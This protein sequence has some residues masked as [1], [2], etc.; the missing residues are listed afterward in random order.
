VIGVD[1]AASTPTSRSRRALA[2]ASATLVALAVALPAALS[3]AAAGAAEQPQ[4]AVADGAAWLASRQQPTGAVPGFGGDWSMTAFAAAGIDAGS[5]RANGAAYSVRDF[6]HRRVWTGGPGSGSDWLTPS[7]TLAY[8]NLVRLATDYERAIIAAWAGGLDPARLSARQNLVAQLA[9]IYHPRPVT[10]DDPDVGPTEGSFGSPALFNG[11]VFGLLALERVADADRPRVPRA[12]LHRIVRTI[13]GN[14][15][16]D[17][18]W[19]FKRVTSQADRDERSDPEL[20]AATL[21]ALCRAG[22]AAD[23][24]LVADGFGF[25]RGRL[26]ADGAIAPDYSATSDTDVT[27]WVVQAA[28]ACGMGDTWPAGLPDG[29]PTPTAFLL[30]RQR[31][32]GSFRATADDDNPAD[33]V[34][35]T[36]AAVG[37]LAGGADD[38]AAGRAGFGADPPAGASWS[39]PRVARGTTVPLTLA[40]VAGDEDDDDP[41]VDVRLCRVDA[42]VGSTV[43]ELLQRAASQASPPGCVTDLALTPD[44]AAVASL[45]GESAPAGRQWSTRRDGGPV[46]VAGSDREVC[47]GDTVSVFLAP[48]AAAE[49]AGPSCPNVASD[50][51]PYVPDPPAPDPGPGTTPGPPGPQPAPGTTPT[52]AP[53][54]APTPEADLPRAPATA[55]LPRVSL[56]ISSARL[57]KSGRMTVRVGCPRKGAPREGCR[58][59]LTAS[60]RHRSWQDGALTRK[61]IGGRTTTVE[62]GRTRTIRF[63]VKAAFRR[64]LRR[65]GRRSVRVEARIRTRDGATGPTRTAQRRVRR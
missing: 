53:P 40:I 47:H 26:R 25:L 38:G 52:P 27:S 5:V 2:T 13:A 55:K 8:G 59:V 44:Q 29:H 48:V 32:D 20:T 51:D 36:Q 1:R 28:H 16:D 12:L 46:T 31:P 65:A 24:P 60:S 49:S 50:P 39:A 63:R 54:P 14:R 4:A 19:T 62:R 23:D 56:R 30:D 41:D 7:T 22:V 11:A 64:D 10:P 18:G 9:G 58:V 33:D 61:R 42:P 57:T 45:N 17:G 3:P 34:N 6:Y 43:V 15:H 21:A 35:T 37:A